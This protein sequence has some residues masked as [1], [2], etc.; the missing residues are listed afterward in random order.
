MSAADAFVTSTVAGLWPE[1][2]GRF[3]ALPSRR[4]P[5]LL[6]DVSRARSGATAVRALAAQRSWKARARREAI[7]TLMR[8]GAGRVVPSAF[9]VPGG[10]GGLTDALS[11]AVGEAVHVSFAVGPP[12]ANRKPVLALT[13]GDGRL[14]GFAKV[15]VDALT[16]ALVDSEAAALRTLEAA[17]LS[18]V[19][20]PHLRWSARWDTYSVVVQSPLPTNRARPLTVQHAARAATDIATIGR[21][22]RP[23][24]A[25]GSWQRDLAALD[26]LDGPAANALRTLAADLADRAGDVDLEIGAAHG[27]WTPWN[28]VVLDD[29]VLAWD[30]E[31][32]AT[33]IPVG[34][35]V[36]HF[37]L[38]AATAGRADALPHVAAA[39]VEQ[40][41]DL[42]AP[43]GIDTTTAPIVAST[44]LLHIG[45]RYLH[46][47]QRAVGG[48]GG[49]I[50]GWLTPALRSAIAAV[51]DLG[52]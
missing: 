40:S 28:A 27:D 1:G 52:G 4:D 6:V 29:E 17:G 35:D 51:P 15:G 31:R 8:L 32:F 14:V 46:D 23:L 13:R 26:D 22:R 49:D 12:R 41:A 25:V 7:A 36:L 18:G 39:A 42:L 19:R 50:E 20:C 5:R 10:R 3:V 45:T 43:T 24:S 9:T 38:N 21:D 37:H 2:E 16:A 30:W 34:H 33:D 11:E 48:R 44:Y 47:G